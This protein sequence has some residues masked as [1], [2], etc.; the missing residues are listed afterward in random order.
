MSEQLEIQSTGNLAATG[1]RRLTPATT[2]VFEGT[3]SLLHCSVKDDTLYRS[4]FAVLLFPITHPHRFISLRWTDENEKIREI[5][6]IDDLNEFSEPEQTLVRAYLA[7]HYHE[8]VI[9]RV[10]SVKVRFGLLFFEVE[11]RRGREQFVMPWQHDRAQDYG[12]KGKVLIDALDNRYIIPDVQALP[13]PDRRR[14]TN[15][16][17]W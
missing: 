7:R 12:A 16:I 10:H 13:A 4:V 11:T 2:R 14:F 3:F 8:P 15:Y 9:T 5:G 17:Y 1:V 6:V